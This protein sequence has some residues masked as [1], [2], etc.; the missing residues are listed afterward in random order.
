MRQLRARLTRVRR[1][2]RWEAAARVWEELGS[3]CASVAGSIPVVMSTDPKD[4]LRLW[5][6]EMRRVAGANAQHCRDQAL[7][8]RSG[9]DG[10]GSYPAPTKAPKLPETS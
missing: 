10:D 8:I 5:L 3:H 4:R 7:R 9:H 2:R 1:A 6:A